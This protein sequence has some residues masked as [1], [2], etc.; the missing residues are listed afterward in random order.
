MEALDEITIKQIKENVYSIL[1]EFI[2]ERDKT[3]N[4][5]LCVLPK[6]NEIRFGIILDNLYLVTDKSPDFYER[7]LGHSLIE[8]QYK[9]FGEEGS[10]IPVEKSIEFTETMS[11]IHMLEE[12][13]ETAQDFIDEFLNENKEL[14]KCINCYID[15]F[16][17]SDY[18]KPPYY[19]FARSYSEEEYSRNNGGS[20][21]IIN[22]IDSAT[23]KYS[24]Y[25]LNIPTTIFCDN[26]DLLNDLC[27]ME[28]IDNMI[29]KYC[30]NSKIKIHIASIRTEMFKNIYNELPNNDLI[31]RG[32]MVY[33]S[34]KA[35]FKLAKNTGILKDEYIQKYEYYMNTPYIESNEYSI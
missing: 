9:R 6:L 8:Y 32:L 3:C 27:S 21:G 22:I 23:M 24:K 2:T 7:V 14:L 33:A 34:N 30:I 19:I 13:Y 26:I 35:L 4:I 18:F 10:T 28:Y 31:S 12:N 20:Q 5:E 11:M 15:S 29:K 17:Y 25:N 1:N 16:N